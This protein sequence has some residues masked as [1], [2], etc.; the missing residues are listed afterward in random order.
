[1]PNRDTEGFKKYVEAAGV[2]GR[3]TRARAEE[4]VH[5]L[6]DAGVL[7]RGQAQ[8]WVDDVVERSR[9][10]SEDLVHMIRTEVSHQLTA[11]GID[12]DNLARQVADLVRQSAEAGRR[13]TSG[14]GATARSTVKKVAAKKPGAK[15]AAAKQ[16]AAKKAPAKKA[17]AKKTAATKAPA[18][19]AAAK[20]APAKKTPGTQAA[21]K[22]SS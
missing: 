1:M 4:I 10:A 15:K 14:A 3:V 13:A 8:E 20:Q 22:A 5:E 7:Q 12:R 18:K 19:K 2:F 17:P 6:V 21:R 16:A 11:M 9:K